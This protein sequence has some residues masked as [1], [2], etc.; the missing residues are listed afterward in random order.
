[1]KVS[2]VFRHPISR[3]AQV[4]EQFNWIFVVIAGGV[5]LLFFMFVIGNVTSAAD[6]K[7][8][9]TVITNFDAIL[10]GAQVTPNA[11]NIIE[12]TKSFGFDVTCDQD[13]LSDLSITDSSVSIPITNKLIYA[14]TTV[15]GEQI[16][17]Y[18]VPIRK[19]FYVGNILLFTD[20]GTLFFLHATASDDAIMDRIAKTFPS[21]I[22]LVRDVFFDESFKNYNHIV[23]VSTKSPPILNN[24][25]DE[26]FGEQV[27]K[28]K[29]VTWIEVK[30]TTAN[31]YSKKDKESIFDFSKRQTTTLHGEEFVSLL[32]F[33]KD[34]HFYDCNYAKLENS[35]RSIASVYATRSLFMANDVRANIDAGADLKEVCA[36]Y[37]DTASNQFKLIAKSNTPYSNPQIAIL[38]DLNRQLLLASCPLV[39]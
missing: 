27:L 37:Y 16:L 29:S 20:P 18:T 35:M 28:R 12:S 1:M 19:P 26:Y 3:K 39:Y 11:L 25:V 32:A 8:K 14:P 9:A 24:G 30:G 15:Q 31:V 13:G 23:V 21:N 10:T 22:S 33:S 4:S 2:S 17:V 5:I 34:A 36:G 38:E 7:V 6:L